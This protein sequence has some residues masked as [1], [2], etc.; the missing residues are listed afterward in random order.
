MYVYIYIYIHIYLS[1]ST[2]RAAPPTSFYG[3]EELLLSCA[4]D[5][6][7]RVWDLRAGKLRETVLGHDRPVHSCAFG[8]RDFFW[9]SGAGGNAQVCGCLDEADLV[10]TRLCACFCWVD[11]PFKVCV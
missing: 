4:A 10:V 3:Q 9:E 11:V 5:R 1:S 2:S 7:L 8:L 6:Q